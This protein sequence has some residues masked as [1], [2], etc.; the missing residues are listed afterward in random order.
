M[1][2]QVT[3]YQCP[4]CTGPLR[5]DGEAGKLVC[6]YCGSQFEVSEIENY[7][8]EKDKKAR[9]NFEKQQTEPQSDDMWDMSYLSTDWGGDAD[10]MKAYGCPS[11][12]A[13]L[14]CDDSTSATSCPYCGNPSIVPG[15]FAGAFR[16]DY[17]IPFKL[18]KDHAVKALANYY[19]GKKF[20]PDAFTKDNKIQ[21]VQGV[22]VPFW[23][24]DGEVDVDLEME[25]STVNTYRQG[26]Y[27]ITETSYY[28]VRR[29]G[30]VPFFKIPV[31]GSTKMPDTHM[32][33]VE[34][35]DYTELKPFSTAYL[36]GYLAERYDQTVSQSADRADRRAEN[37]AVDVM[38]ADVSGYASCMVTGKHT[39]LKR[40]KVSYALM[41]VYMLNTKWN[42][43]DYL[44]AMNGQTG[45]FIGNLPVDKGKY[46]KTFFGIAAAVTALLGTAMMLVL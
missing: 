21:E 24:F 40:G 22:Y 34:P 35:F 31:D 17:V 9:E 27:R 8:A 41:P 7:Y 2:T 45:K 3:N 36:P 42:G 16:P 1:A 32:D 14:I 43:N 20:L 18:S 28:D 11:C 39:H 46:W 19:K 29:A 33:A 5:F 30:T 12:G 26:D 37:T 25:A 23:L 44:F 6:D 15:Q 4:S 13:Q 10:R 38:R